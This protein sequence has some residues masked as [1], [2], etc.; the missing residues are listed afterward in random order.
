MAPS[1]R[2]LLTLL[3]IADLSVVTASFMTAFVTAGDVAGVHNW[4][5]LL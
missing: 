1:R 5:E 4:L 3:K 2:G